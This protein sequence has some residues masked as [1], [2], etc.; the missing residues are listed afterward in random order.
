[1]T[2][3]EH[4]VRR[5]LVVDDHPI[6]RQGVMQLLEREPDLK[7][8]G[9]AADADEARAAIAAERP[10]GIILDL[11]LR[12]SDGMEVLR[13]LRRENRSVPVLILSRRDEHIFAERLL[14]AGA[15]GYIMK[16]AATDQV[17]LALRRVLEGGVYVSEQ[18]GAGLDRRSPTA[19]SNGRDPVS[20]L[21]R[22]ELEVLR[23]IGRGKATREIAAELSLSVKT[24]ESHRQRIKRKLNL[25]SAPQ[26]VQFAVNWCS[27]RR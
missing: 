25:T 14:S 19:R 5:V 26:L 16:Q 8:C 3:V 11:S 21:S 6:V 22:R 24:V 20:R 12:N 4:R 13:E 9:Q 15:N 1:M 17:L 23:L 2:E 27:D 10:D 18:I 7:V